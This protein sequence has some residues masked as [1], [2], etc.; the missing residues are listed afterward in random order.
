M[1][2]LKQ[3]A[4]SRL[5][6]Y[7]CIGENIAFLRILDSGVVHIKAW[8]DAPTLTEWLTARNRGKRDLWLS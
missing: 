5:M 2:S 1:D 6:Y 7:K 8:W 4:L 3:E